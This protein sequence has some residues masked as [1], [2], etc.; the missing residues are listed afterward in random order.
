LVPGGEIVLTLALLD[1]S[2]SFTSA[3]GSNSYAVQPAAGEVWNIS[4]WLQLADNGGVGDDVYIC[5]YTDN[6][7]SA[8]IDTDIANNSAS[9]FAPHIVLSNDNTLWLKGVSDGVG[10]GARHYKYRYQGW[11]Y[12]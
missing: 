8:T 6:V 4:C 5:L 2:N 9:A 7:E 11:K 1:V 10:A 3:S 12:T